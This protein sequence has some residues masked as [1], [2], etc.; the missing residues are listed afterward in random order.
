MKSVIIK[1]RDELALTPARSNVLD[2]IEAGI[3]LVLPS[4][5]IRDALKYDRIKKNLV[6]KGDVFSVARGRVFVI[7]G[8]KASGLMALTLEEILG[9][10]LIT[11]GH[12]TCKSDTLNTQRIKIIPAGHPIPDDRGLS[13]VKDMFNL[14]DIYSIDKDDLVLCLI[15]G[16]GS[17][18]MPCP[19]DGVSLQDKQTVTR[20]LLNSGAEIDEINTVRKHLSQVKGGRLGAHFSPATVVSLIVSDVVGNDVSAIASGP[21]VPDPSTFS[22]AFCVLEKHHLLAK[23]PA[24]I[25]EHLQKGC[26]GLVEETPKV[27]NNCRNYII[28]DN[29]LALEAMAQKAGEIGYHPCIIT[30]EQK[31][32]TSD[33]AWFRAKQVINANNREYDL[34][35]LG[36]ETTLNVPESAGRGGR[37]Q[38]YAVVSLL[39]FKGLKREWVVA[40]VGTDGSDYLPEVAGALIDSHSVENLILKNI[41]PQSYI[42]RFDSHTL[43]AK[44]GNSLIMTGNTGTNVGDVFIYLIK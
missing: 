11:D 41:D 17:A 35:L 18:L 40:S 42:E 8:G 10:G 15:S 43:L 4:E 24:A 23:I 22:Q 9:P 32:N 5:V 31:G 6:V 30:A 7:G 38:H 12:V 25:I 39:A 37:N 20:L 21:T 16:G 33:V 29:T 1:N 14:K 19:V 27:L 13:G 36:G 26:R 2:I 34:F 3:A 44:L 28:G